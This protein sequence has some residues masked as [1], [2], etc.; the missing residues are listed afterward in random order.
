MAVLPKTIYMFNAIPTKIPMTFIHRD[1]KINPKVHLKAQK[2]ANSPTNT[3]HSTSKNVLSLL[4]LLM[5]SLQ[6]N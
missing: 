2:T 4:L 3:E 5:F 6:Q 1:L